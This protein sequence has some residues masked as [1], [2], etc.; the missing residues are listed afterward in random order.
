MDDSFSILGWLYFSSFLA[1]CDLKLFLLCFLCLNSL[2]PSPASLGHGLRHLFLS[3]S[4]NSPTQGGQ[5]S[6]PPLSLSIYL[7]I[8]LSL[9][10]TDWNPQKQSPEQILDKFGFETFF[11]CCKGSVA[12][13]QGTHGHLIHPCWT[14]MC[15]PELSYGMAAGCL[16]ETNFP[17]L[18]ETLVCKMKIQPKHGQN[19]GHEKEGSVKHLC[20]S[21]AIF[22][23]L[24]S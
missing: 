24:I 3:V 15:T 21:C 22:L 8:Y 10:V 16:S 1:D 18:H 20:S 4:D 19:Q 23:S 2:L 5:S 9:F 6:S 11:D 13:P 12:N 7:S 17:Y 14:N